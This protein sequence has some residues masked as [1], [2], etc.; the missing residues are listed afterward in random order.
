ME[1]PILDMYTGI[2]FKYDYCISQQILFLNLDPNH[3]PSWFVSKLWTVLVPI[4]WSW[5]IF[6]KFNYAA[7]LLVIV[8]FANIIHLKSHISTHFS[9]AW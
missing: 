8:T 5:C 7:H 9:Y 4:Q 2:F 1:D 3:L 6:L